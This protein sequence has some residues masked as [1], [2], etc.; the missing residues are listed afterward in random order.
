MFVLGIKRRK[1]SKDLKREEK[2]GKGCK[3]KVKKNTKD[4]VGRQ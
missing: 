4:F 3:R 2:K 1:K